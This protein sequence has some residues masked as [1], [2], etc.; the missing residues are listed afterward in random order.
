MDSNSKKETEEESNHIPADEP[1][2]AGFVLNKRYKIERLINAEV[3][4]LYI[5]QLI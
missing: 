1:L 5:K 2:P 4:E 3:W